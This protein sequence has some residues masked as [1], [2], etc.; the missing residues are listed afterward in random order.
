MKSIVSIAIAGVAVFALSGCGGDGSGGAL[1]GSSLVKDYV[2]NGSN[3]RYDS[4]INLLNAPSSSE[5]ICD[6]Y[7]AP[8]S[9]NRWSRLTGTPITPGN[10]HEWGSDNCNQS[11]DL[12]V[13]D[14]AGNESI[15]TYYRECYT[16]TYFTFKNW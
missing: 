14:C 10:T 12:R 9:S 13:V 2:Q 8:A 6:V 3:T 5:D 11:W 16:T 1:G 4:S 15:K 7:S